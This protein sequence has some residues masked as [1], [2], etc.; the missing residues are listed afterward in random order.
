M[1]SRSAWLATIAG[2]I[3]GAVAWP[4]VSKLVYL[5]DEGGWTAPAQLD[6]VVVFV[7][8][9]LS[10]PGAIVDGRGYL[11]LAVVSGFWTIV[12]AFIANRLEFWLR[13]KARF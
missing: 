9:V 13:A 7:W 3:L 10:M 5:F 8:M 11:T 4:L 2:G 12:G 1:R 6:V